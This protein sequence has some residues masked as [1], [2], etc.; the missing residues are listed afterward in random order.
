MN[1]QQ[2]YNYYLPNGSWSG[3]YYGNVSDVTN[4][5]NGSGSY[6][7]SGLSWSN[8]SNYCNPNS[9]Y[10]VWSMVVVY[11]KASLPV[12]SI[13]VYKSFEKSWPASN[14]SFD[15]DKLADNHCAR[16]AQVTHISYEGD[17]YKGED[18]WINGEYKGLSLIHI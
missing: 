5:V 11:E 6:K 4:K 13:N 12:S 10:G 15:I 1:S 8:A 9:A 16:S 18:L 17:H 14:W 3:N 2:S 7:V